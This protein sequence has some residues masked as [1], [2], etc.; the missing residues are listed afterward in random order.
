MISTYWKT[1]VCTSRPPSLIQHD[2]VHFPFF[3]SLFSDIKEPGF[4][5][6][7]NTCSSDQISSVRPT[8]H[9]WHPL[10]LTGASALPSCSGYDISLCLRVGGGKEVGSSTL[11]R[12][13]QNQHLGRGGGDRHCHSAIEGECSPGEGGLCDAFNL[14]QWHLLSSH[15]Q[16]EHS[17]RLE[18]ERWRTGKLLF[19]LLLMFSPQ[20]VSDSLQPHGLQHTSGKPI[21]RHKERPERMAERR[22]RE[23]EEN[24][25]LG[26][27]YDRNHTIL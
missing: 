14:P 19:L 26:L 24:R 25:D 13:R 12:G 22:E 23:E 10:G 3:V 17:K 27:M 6:L 20:V 21:G 8:S 5:L 7:D 15:C 2:S 18:T 4:Q 1:C 9:L 16:M 11:P